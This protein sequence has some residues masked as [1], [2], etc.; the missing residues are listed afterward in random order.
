[1]DDTHTWHL[2]YE[3]IDP[4]ADVDVPPQNVVPMF[5]VPLM[6]H[7]DF[8]LGQDFVAWHE[9]GEITDR[10]QE[11]LGQSDEGVILLRQMLLEQIDVAERGDDPIN[12]FRDPA[13]NEYLSL[14]TEDYGDFSDYEEGS[15]AYY[16]T[17]P[18][19]YITEV[20]A[21]YKKAKQRALLKH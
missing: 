4:G 10:T 18:Y 1:M 2:H 15:F 13:N 21:L 16:D 12:V 6:E 5:E 3:V 19:G 7:P 20:E 11:M 17:G 14:P 8:I 9:Q